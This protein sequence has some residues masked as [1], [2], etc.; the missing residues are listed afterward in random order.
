MRFAIAIEFF[1]IELRRLTLAVRESNASGIASIDLSVVPTISFRLLYGLLVL[2][3]D[4]RRILWLG[5]TAHP[6]AE[7]IAQQV[8]EACG[9]ESAPHYLIRRLGPL[10]WFEER[11]LAQG[12]VAFEDVDQGR[13]AAAKIILQP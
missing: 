4:R 5:V 11:P 7:W 12:A 1:M 10:D 9:W 6:S 13:S 3:H 8:T 2:R